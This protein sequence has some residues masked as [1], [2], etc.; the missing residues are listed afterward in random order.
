MLER[1]TAAMFHASINPFHLA[2]AARVQH[3]PS[4][5]DRQLVALSNEKGIQA[6]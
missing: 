2:Y 6:A 1:L 5:D 4:A 3:I